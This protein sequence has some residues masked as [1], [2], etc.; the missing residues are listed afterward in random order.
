MVK[1]RKKKVEIEE[2]QLR[3]LSNWENGRV[4]TSPLT[5]YLFEIVDSRDKLSV[6]LFW[7]EIGYF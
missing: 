7:I 3:E 5:I 2:L 6:R 4:E 1:N